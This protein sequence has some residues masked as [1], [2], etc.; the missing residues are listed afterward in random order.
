MSSILNSK[1]S[2][3]EDNDALLSSAE[4]MK[5]IYTKQPK[6]KTCKLCNTLVNISEPYY[7]SHGT[8]FYKCSVCGHIYGQY[9]DGEQYSEDLYT[10]GLY[11]GNYRE[12]SSK[13]YIQRLESIYIPKVQFLVDTLEMLETSYES[14]RYLDI[15]TG[16]GYMVG[17]YKRYGLNAQ[18]TDVDVNQVLYGNKMLNEELLYATKLSEMENVVAKTN[19]EVVSFI[20]VLEHISN[21]QDILAAVKENKNISF[22]FFSVPKF[23]LSC[24]L[25]IVFP[26]VFPRQIGGGGGHTHLFTDKSIEWMCEKYGLTPVAKWQFGTDMMDLYRSLSVMLKKSKASDALVSEM[27]ELFAVHTDDLQAVIDKTNWASEVHII[28][29]KTDEIS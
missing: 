16:A 14:F 11:G 29:K 20:G 3:F 21:L 1:R 13:K 5:K 17:A 10:S 25:E 26:S 2:F 6:R 19:C 12:D 18:G 8:S 28:A 22:V 4:Q 24:I 15:G 7:Y 23:S 9:E 27:N